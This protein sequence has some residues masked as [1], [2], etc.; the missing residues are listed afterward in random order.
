MHC[1][2][3]RMGIL[4]HSC[5]RMGILTH[6]CKTYEHSDTYMYYTT[7]REHNNMRRLHLEANNL[8]L[9]IFKARG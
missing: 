4:T 1:S 7:I 2:V 8:L 3:K 9:C 6:T 5:K